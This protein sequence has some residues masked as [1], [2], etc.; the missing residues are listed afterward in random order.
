MFSNPSLST[1][2]I[3]AQKMTKL[4]FFS[5]RFNKY[6]LHKVENV[7]CLIKIISATQLCVNSF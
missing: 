3:D 5:G 1:T 4:E 6:M 7:E 2:K